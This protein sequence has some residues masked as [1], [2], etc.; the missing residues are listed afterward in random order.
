MH[1]E[2]PQLPE[3]PESHCD[4]STGRSRQR[5]LGIPFQVAAKEVEAVMNQ[6]AKLVGN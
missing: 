4:T 1:T 3:T 6:Q 2:H 5:A